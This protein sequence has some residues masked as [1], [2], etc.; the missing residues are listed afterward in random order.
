MTVKHIENMDEYKT[1][2]ELSK[3]KLVVIDFSAEWCVRDCECVCVMIH[4]VS[5]YVFSYPV[6]FFFPFY[7]D[8]LSSGAVRAK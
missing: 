2:L 3:T 6:T 7:L 5:V 4:F 8:S 1:L